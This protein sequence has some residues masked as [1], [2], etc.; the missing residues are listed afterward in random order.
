MRTESPSENRE[1]D[2]QWL[3]NNHTLAGRRD[4]GSRP[5]PWAL[6]GT[7]PSLSPRTQRPLLQV[8]E[9]EGGSWEGLWGLL[10][11]EIRKRKS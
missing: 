8:G 5:V 1:A 9:R 11:S 2:E 7:P 10:G 6:L 4:S 3:C